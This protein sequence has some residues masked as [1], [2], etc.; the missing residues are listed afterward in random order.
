[1]S[2]RSKTI[3]RRQKLKVTKPPTVELPQGPQK[4]LSPADRLTL[5]ELDSVRGLLNKAE[6]RMLSRAS[7][8]GQAAD[9]CTLTISL[10]EDCVE[11]LTVLLSI[12][13]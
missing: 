6:V 11:R 4:V 12:L 13:R 3:P 10:L 5:H 8:A 9:D 2:T 1:M 7:D